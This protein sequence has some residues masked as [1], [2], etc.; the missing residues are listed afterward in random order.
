MKLLGITDLHGDYPAL[1]RIL[2]DAG[3]VDVILLGGDITH[4]GTPNAA[5]SIVRYVQPSARQVLAVAGNC[6]SAAIDQ[7]LAELGVSLFHR[8]VV[9]DGVGFYG[10]SAMPPWGGHMYELTEAEIAAT[11]QAGREQL[12]EPLREVLLSHP[13]PHA[14]RLDRTYRGEHV[15][16]RAVRRFIEETHPALVL[17][18]HIHEARGVDTLGVTTVVNCG[19]ARRGQYA[20]VEVSA[21]IQVELRAAEGS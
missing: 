1:D 5:E 18:G 10:V 16:S 19:H 7:R 9:L 21:S 13:P 15:G 8:G 2:K 4:F 14:T 20:V 3:P 6:D 11:L 12:G 17:C